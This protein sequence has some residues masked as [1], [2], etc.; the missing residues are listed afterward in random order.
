M[1]LRAGNARHL[2]A[3]RRGRAR[4]KSSARRRI[5][6]RERSNDGSLCSSWS[7]ASASDGAQQRSG[8][9]RWAGQG[10]ASETSL[11]VDTAEPG[12]ENAVLPGPKTA[13]PAPIRGRPTTARKPWEPQIGVCGT[14]PSHLLGD[15]MLALE[16]EDGA[17]G[18]RA[19]G[20][21]DVRDQ[22]D[23]REEVASRAMNPVVSQHGLRLCHVTQPALD[24]HSHAPASN[25]ID[26]FRSGRA[27]AS[28]DQT[29]PLMSTQRTRR[30]ACFFQASRSGYHGRSASRASA[31]E[32]RLEGAP[33]VAVSGVGS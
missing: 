23:Q 1:S 10:S 24:Y 15:A 14:D 18:G 5:P 6:D 33:H 12:A 7:I 19:E 8:K 17:A 3:G 21:S 30:P 11:P 29:D 31:A 9:H 32:G 27:G 4:T 28:S 2:V 13:S 20:R 16:I 25:R 22:D 26:H